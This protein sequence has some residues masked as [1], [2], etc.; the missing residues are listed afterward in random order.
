MIPKLENALSANARFKWAFYNKDKFDG[1]LCSYVRLQGP[2]LYQVLHTPLLDHLLQCLEND[3]STTVIALALTVLI[4]F[5][6]H[7]CNSLSSYLPRLFVVYTRV[8]CWDKFGV[9]RIDEHRFSSMDAYSRTG[10]PISVADE[11]V[12]GDAWQKLNSSFETASSTMPDVSDYFSFLYGL[13]PINFLSFIREPYKF[14]ERVNFKDIDQL[15]MDEETIRQ[16]T[17]PYRQSHTLHPNFLYLTAET[18]LKDQSRWMRVEPADVTA[19][20]IG[21]VNNNTPYERRAQDHTR[22]M[23][24]ALV[25]TEEIPDESLLSRETDQF[26]KQ[27]DEL[28]S[29]A[30]RQINRTT[31]G[32]SSTS[33]SRHSRGAPDSPTIPSTGF[34]APTKKLQLQDMLNLQGELQLQ[35]CLDTASHPVG[36]PPVYPGIATHSPRL[37]AYVNS[38][39]D[40]AMPRSPALRPSLTDA[41]GTIAYLQREVML[42]KNDLNF[43]R[44]L[45]QQHLSHIGHLQRKHIRESTAEAETQNLINSNM[46]LKAKL[47]DAGR[48]YAASRQEA[49]KSKNQAKKWEAELSAKIRAL[50]E[51]QKVWRMEEEATKAALKGATDETEQLRRLLQDSE[52]DALRARQKLLSMNASME[53][54]NKLRTFVEHLSNKLTE[55]DERAQQFE[56][57][58]HNEESA[59]NQVEHMQMKVDAHGRRDAC[60]ER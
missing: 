31:G 40:N 44:Y 8:L 29:A 27:E 13:Y 54:V 5:M 42:L 37:E 45:K 36:P 59:L 51:E 48:A 21:L 11:S 50:R 24:E 4:M 9:V 46:T 7:V 47:E 39:S 58:R 6:P 10:T 28:D 19:Q 55:Y 12:N 38:L 23:P 17:E 52:A 57:Q 1:L 2:H 3:T 16:R 15:D 30:R 14:L 20:C 49:L 33:T 41:N 34:E 35:T 56:L 22:V 60:D 32:S 43:E 26:P 25:L 53:E 18:E